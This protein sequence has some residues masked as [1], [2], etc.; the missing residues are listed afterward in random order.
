MRCFSPGLDIGHIDVRHLI[1][2]LKYAFISPLLLFTNYHLVNN[3]L[4]ERQLFYVRPIL[5][6]YQRKLTTAI[7]VLPK[8]WKY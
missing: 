8:S 4:H 3:P 5:P 6:S 1:R 7:K 2:P